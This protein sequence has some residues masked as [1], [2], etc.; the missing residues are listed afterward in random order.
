MN[1][2]CR[3]LVGAL[4]GVAAHVAAQLGQLHGG[5]VALGALVRLLVGVLVAHVADQLACHKH[6]GEIAPRGP[7]TQLLSSMI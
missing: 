4:A 5:V 2:R 1:R 3:Y 6:Y 7:L